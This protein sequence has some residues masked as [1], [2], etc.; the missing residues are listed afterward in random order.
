MIKKITVGFLLSM[1][2]LNYSHAAQVTGLSC[3]TPAP[4]DGLS[5][6][7]LKRG[8]GEPV[9]TQVVEQTNCK[10]PVQEVSN[11]GET[12]FIYATKKNNVM[13]ARRDTYICVDPRE[14]LPPFPATFVIK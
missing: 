12:C 10:F 13:A 3:S 8:P 11:E 14:T 7:L 1:S 6:V 4:A 2:L 9:Y 5:F